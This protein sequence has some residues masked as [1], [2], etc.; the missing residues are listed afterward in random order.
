[1]RTFL[2]RTCSGAPGFTFV[3][4]MVVLAVM[5]LLTV[6][7]IPAFRTV[8]ESQR[9]RELNRFMAILRQMCIDAVLNRSPLRLEIDLSAQEYR[10][11]RRDS[12]GR[13]AP[14]PKGQ[15]LAPR[16]LP[17]SIRFVDV[18]PYGATG[19]P[20]TVRTATIQIDSSGF[21]DPFLLHVRENHDPWTLRVGFTCKPELISGNSDALLH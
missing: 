2:R 6:I 4:V 15:P 16:Q 13:F 3:E 10:P 18:V 8:F 19:S 20:I 9:D 1:M 11:L 17:E 5:T 12:Y 14:L 7:A 21:I